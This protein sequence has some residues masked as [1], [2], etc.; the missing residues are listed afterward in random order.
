MGTEKQ[1]RNIAPLN[2]DKNPS[3]LTKRLKPW[4]MFR[5]P[6]TEFS[7]LPPVCATSALWICI[8]NFTISKGVVAHPAIDPATDEHNIL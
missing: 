8:L 1:I 2:R 5:Y 7:S 6:N 4:K 3:F